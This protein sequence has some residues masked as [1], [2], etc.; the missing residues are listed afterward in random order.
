MQTGRNE[1][2]LRQI[3]TCSE[4][5]TPAAPKSHRANGTDKAAPLATK[6]CLWQQ[7]PAV[8][9]QTKEVVC[10]WILEADDLGD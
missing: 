7:S 4:K 5:Q 2:R 10:E 9:N 3:N 1:D 6:R 8:N